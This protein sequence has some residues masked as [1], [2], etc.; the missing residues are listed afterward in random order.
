MLLIVTKWFKNTVLQ[1]IAWVW[2]E[3][4]CISLIL[5]TSWFLR[6]LQIDVD[7]ILLYLGYLLASSAKHCSLC[8]RETL[9][10]PVRETEHG[11]A[12]NQCVLVG[13][14]WYEFYGCMC[15]WCSVCPFPGAASMRCAWLWMRW[16]KARASMRG[17]RLL[18]WECC[19]CYLSA[20]GLFYCVAVVFWCH[21]ETPC[22]VC[23]M[24]I[25]LIL[26]CCRCSLLLKLGTRLKI[27]ETCKDQVSQT[28]SFPTMIF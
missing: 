26:M 9:S 10:R 13:L 27:T 20:W 28:Y 2:R 15:L 8:C 22:N 17:N 16:L 3:Q 7:Y 19:T 21:S 18:A 23:N 1:F 4:K 25:N 6:L 12:P 11:V 24:L 5:I 14:C